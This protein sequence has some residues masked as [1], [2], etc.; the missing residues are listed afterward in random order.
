M[1]SSRLGAGS[2]SLFRSCFSRK[3]PHWLGEEQTEDKTGPSI[4]TK[5]WAENA[6]DPPKHVSWLGLCVNR[7]AVSHCDMFVLLQKNILEIK[8][9]WRASAERNLIRCEECGA[10]SGCTHVFQGGRRGQELIR[11]QPSPVFFPLE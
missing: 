1:D 5:L 3:G 11:V 10:Q 7:L 4:S 2:K 6:N 8:D 9:E